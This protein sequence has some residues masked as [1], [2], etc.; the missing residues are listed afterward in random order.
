MDRR[1]R[2]GEKV[3]I[4][5]LHADDIH[6]ALAS[7]LIVGLQDIVKVTNDHVSVAGC[8]DL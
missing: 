3:V 4:Y 1:I 7:Y 8:R 6:K 5:G 2:S